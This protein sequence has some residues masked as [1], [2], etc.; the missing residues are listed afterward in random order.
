ME[1]GSEFSVTRRRVGDAVI[2]APAGEIDLAT[3]DAVAAEIDAGSAEAALV[4]LD[5]RAVTFLDSAGI[6]LVLTSARRLA[7][8]GGELAVVHGPAEVQRVFNL[9]GL[10]GRV[11]LLDAPP[12][13]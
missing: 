7:A 6:R 5:L 11:R 8:A 1:A 10:D 3:I 2:V 13:E 9:V 4:V 12:G